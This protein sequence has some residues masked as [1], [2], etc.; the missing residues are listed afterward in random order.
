MI[1]FS[2]P[3]IKEQPM[4]TIQIFDLSSDENKSISTYSI[5]DLS[6]KDLNMHGGIL[7]LLVLSF[8][9]GYA[10]GTGINYLIDKALY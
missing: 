8:G 6:N 3:R 10:V 7:C 5:E 9:A 4:S 2:K 1:M